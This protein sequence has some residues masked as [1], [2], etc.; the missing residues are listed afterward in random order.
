MQPYFGN[1]LHYQDAGRRG[2]S[3]ILDI[4]NLMSHHKGSP[5]WRQYTDMGFIQARWSDDDPLRDTFL[6]ELGAFPA[7]E[8]MGIDYGEL[9]K[10]AAEP[11]EIREVVIDANAPLPTELMAHPS[12]ASLSRFGMRRHYTI[13]GSDLPAGVYAG[14]ATSLPDLVDFWNLRAA[15]VSLRFYDRAHAARYE[16][17]H[18]AMIE[19]LAQAVA[20]LDEH[21]RRLAVVS[22]DMMT[23]EEVQAIL[24]DEPEPFLVRTGGMARFRRVPMMVLGEAS[25]LGVVS[26]DRSSPTISFAFG[27]KPFNG[28]TWFHS[29]HLVASLNLARSFFDGD[30]YTFELPYLPELNENFARKAG[31]TYDSLRLEPERT[32]IVIAA[33]DHDSQVS[34]IAVWDIAEAVFQQVGLKASVSNAGLMTRQLITQ[35]G[36]VDKTRAFKIPGV[37]RLIKAF[38]PRQ[39]FKKRVALEF[40]GGRDPENSAA[41]F[42]DHARLFIE[43]RPTDEPLTA[44]SVFSHLVERGLF[45]M[46]ADLKC[47]SCRLTSW[48]P[49]EQLRQQVT[50][51]LCGTSHD[52]TRQLVEGDSTYR[53]TG[54][55]GLEQNTQGAV[56]VAL[57]M[58]QLSV[59]VFS[60]FKEGFVLPSIDAEPLDGSAQR[61]ELDVF[62]LVRGRPL[63]PIQIMFGEVKDR[64][65]TINANDIANLQRIAAM[66]KLY[67]FEVYPLLA[68][69]SRFSEEEITLAA[70]LAVDHEVILLTD[71][72]LEP[73]HIYDRQPHEAG[74]IR[75]AGSFPDLAQAT[76]Q[77]YPGLH[78]PAPAAPVAAAEP[79]AN[80]AAPA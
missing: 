49:L 2:R 38:G 46:G 72:E 13:R 39:S 73:Y 67:G 42:A 40:I 6:I 37:R 44:K 50:C 3:R 76:W 22:P 12:V 75:Y 74:H 34:A 57:L 30:Q 18:E 31:V 41:N 48:V 7:T 28:D 62:A 36:G 51:E 11:S 25:A 68:K 64:G 23:A 17:I 53:R 55:L 54:I 70:G 24:R 5:L 66:F 1:G 45:R 78:P 10:L 69:L 79:V 61:C 26:K 80:E 32:G 60:H 27:D 14:D 16:Q 9:L 4:E 35:M 52:A 71:Q 59:N 8:E 19:Q 47:P 56:P 33:A 15:D 65:G 63:E 77:L 29:Q 20:H 43:P 58:Q 21:G